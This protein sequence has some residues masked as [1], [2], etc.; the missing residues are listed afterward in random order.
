MSMILREF[1][2]LRVLFL[3]VL[4]AVWS[5]TAYLGVSCEKTVHS[6][7]N[8]WLPCRALFSRDDDIANRAY[9]K[10]WAGLTAGPHG[11]SSLFEAALRGNPVSPYRWCDLG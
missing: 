2:F 7:D 6:A 11:A 1:P 9:K 4:L 10:T 5:S 3:V 8:P